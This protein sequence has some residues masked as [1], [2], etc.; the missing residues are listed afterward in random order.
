MMSVLSLCLPNSF[1]TFLPL[2]GYFN[3]C[4]YHLLDTCY[5]QLHESYSFSSY[6]YQFRSTP[7]IQEGPGYTETKDPQLSVAQHCEVLGFCS[8]IQAKWV[9]SI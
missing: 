3:E 9:S 8:R 4:L 2:N 7:P 5:I 6:S 1:P